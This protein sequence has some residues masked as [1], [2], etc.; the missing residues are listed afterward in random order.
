MTAGA[1]AD[2]HAAITPRQLALLLLVS[3]VWGSHWPIMKI[4]LVDVSPLWFR[5]VTIS[6]GALMLAFW[7]LA[8]RQRLLPS[9]SDL[10]KVL[11]VGACNIAGWHGLSIIG[12]TQLPAGR[13][14]V[15][16]FTMPI[17]AVLL[18]ALL[19]GAALT[20]RS[21]TAAICIAIAVALLT[22][23][24][25]STLAGRPAGIAWMQ[26]AA[27]L[28]AFGTILL[29]RL[30]ISIGT[31]A[32]T[33][34]MMVV[35]AVTFL[36]MAPLL[37]PP[38]QPSEWR[39]ATWW[40]VAFGIVINFGVAQAAWFAIARELPTQISSF[41]IMTVPVVGI[42]ASFFLIGEVPRLTDWVALAFIVMAI[43]LVNLAPSTARNEG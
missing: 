27:I 16:G 7:V 26:G 29:R 20:R 24:E 23:Q 21:I 3:L 28:W 10:P 41:S 17:W 37:E 25:L 1:P 18:G 22:W 8:K 15:L 12:L 34:W 42:V 30:H 13:A 43:A 39:A 31:E 6:G 38:V 14:G 36:V 33:V 40:A 4:A 19:F 5:F 11:L 9:A 35:G 2:R 32:L